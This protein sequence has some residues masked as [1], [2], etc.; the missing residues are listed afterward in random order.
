[1]AS[2][3][4]RGRQPRFLPRMRLGGLPQLDPVTLG[5]GDP[6]EPADT[7]HLLGVLGH[8]RSFGTQL[9]DHR[10][11]V[12]D[13]EVEH[14]LLGAGPEVAG[15][16]LERREYRRPGFLAPQAVLIGVQAQAIAVP[17]AQ[18][19]RVGGAHEVSADA[20]HTF[21]AAILPAEP[22][23][24]WPTGPARRRGLKT[25]CPGLASRGM[26]AV[27]DRD[28]ITAEVAARLVADQF[29]Q[30]AGLPVV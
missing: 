22:P 6:A 11:Q 21:H 2:K 7:L 20:K 18:G 19:R 9:R 3:S 15:L 13:A 8:L 23:R 1:M 28:E 14:R 10:V 30:W 4:G 17:R 16:G 27:M 5:I 26:I 29:P 24:A 12:A 25:G